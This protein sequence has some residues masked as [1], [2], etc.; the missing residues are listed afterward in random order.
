MSR[1]SR[2]QAGDAEQVTLAREQVQRQDEQS[3]E[4]CRLEDL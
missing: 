2:G 1:R 3:P 4:Q